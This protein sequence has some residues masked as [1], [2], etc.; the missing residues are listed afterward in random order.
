M[1]VIRTGTHSIRMFS[2]PAKISFGFAGYIQALLSTFK[3]VLEQYLLD[4]AP[5]GLPFKEA[6]HHSNTQVIKGAVTTSPPAKDGRPPPP[7]G[8]FHQSQGQ[9]PLPQLY[10]AS[11]QGQ[12]TTQPA[13]LSAPSPSMTAA[14]VLGGP[15]TFPPDTIG[16]VGRLSASLLPAETDGEPL[17][18]DEGFSMAAHLV[19]M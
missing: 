10:Q 3:E 13:L 4:K 12:P 9:H 15:S 11:P 1:L 2:Q 8:G 19:Y 6:S 7:Q 18:L 17:K 14:S 16:R 5:P